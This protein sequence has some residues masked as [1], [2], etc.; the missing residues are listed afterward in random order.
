MHYGVD[1]YPEHEDEQTWGRD[2][3]LIAEAGFTVVRLAEFAWA[4]LEPQIGQFTFG[5]LD[6][7]ITCLANQGL[8]IVLGT[9]TA[10]PPQWLSAAHADILYVDRLGRRAAPQSRRFVCLSS[11]TFRA[12]SQHIV[13][14]M[15]EHYRDHRAVIGWQIDNEFGCHETS[16]CYCP[17]CHAAFR[18]WLHEKYSTLG[19]LNAVWGSG[20]WGQEY[21]DWSQINLPLP[22]PTYHNPGHVLDACRFASDLTC[23]YQQL[24]LT[25]LREYAP[26]RI[27]FH[28]FM[29]N[30]D[31][32]DYAALAAPLDLVAWDNYVPD[33][34]RWHDTARYHDMMRGY[35]HTPFWVVESPPGQVNWTRYNP[36]LRPG[37]ARLRS[38]QAIA[39]GADGIFYFHWRAFRGGGE[40]YHSAILPHDGIPGR[41]YREAAQLGTELARLKPLLEGTTVASRVAIVH[42]MASYWALQHQ[43]Q[44]A[45]LGDP[46]CYV[47]PW[48][49]ALCQRNVAVEFCQPTDDLSSY[50][51]VI[52]PSLHVL[53][54]EAATNLRD[55][56]ERGGILVLGPR[57]GFKEPGNRVVDQPLPGLLAELAGVRVAEWAAL[58]PGE[59][60]TINRPDAQHTYDISLWREVLELRGAEAIAHYTGGY[61]DGAV[62]IARNRSGSGSTVYVGVL[63]DDL[64]DALVA[65]LLHE[66][67]ITGALATPPGV[68]ACVRE[69]SHGRFLLLLNHTPDEH[70][71]DLPQPVLDVLHETSLHESIRIAPLDTRVLKLSR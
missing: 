48:Y 21:H 20:F 23:E 62:A 65:T 24:Q 49:D 17:T 35:K 16:R 34:V 5:W 41:Q 10:A 25:I 42:D 39:H 58:P 13:T 44:S 3:H 66:T 67:G 61:D 4:R 29:A 68:E 55:Y 46:Q 15:A 11:S 28:N 37:E 9:P 38:L 43:P 53:R 14:A 50:D 70:V 6:Q 60:R 56:V 69:G 8:A 57:T 51:L 54:P 22:T 33:G 71:I 31:Q 30:F 12:A 19:A 64:I 47:K 32:L 26:G 7:V 2:A 40:Q 59:T 1:Y 18:D 52:A 36:D 63:G 27:I 45:P